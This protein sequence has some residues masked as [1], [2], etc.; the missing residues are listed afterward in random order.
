M[1]RCRWE[2]FLALLHLAAT[3]MCLHEFIAP[4]HGSGTGSPEVSVLM[5][6]KMSLQDPEKLLDK[7]AA[8]DQTPCQWTGVTCDQTTQV[9]TGVDLSN[10]NL[11]GPV[12]TQVC[13]LQNLTSYNVGNNYLG[14]D[15][16]D[17]LLDCSKLEYLNLSQNLIVSLLPNNISKLQNL[18]HLDLCANNFTGAIPPGFGDLPLLESLNLTSNLLNETIPGYLG[19]LYNLK[20]L[21]LAINPFAPGEIPPELGNLNRLVNLHLAMANLVGPIP[22]SFGNLT[23]LTDFLDLS[24]NNL[25]GSIP[26]GIMGLPKLKK[27]ELYI[28]NLT[29]QIP[30]NMTKLVSITD[31]DL[32]ENGLTGTIP[33]DIAKLPNLQLLHLWG[34]Q[35]KGE[36][37]PGL[38]NL[39]NLSMLRLFSNNLTGEL[40]QNFGQQGTAFMYFDVSGNALSGPVPPDLCKGGQLQDLLLFNNKFSG[41]I[42]ET[43]GNC[44]SLQRF[45]VNQNNLNGQIPEALWKAPYLHYADFSDNSFTGGI[46]PSIG[47]AANLTILDVSN[48]RLSGE[49]PPEIGKLFKLNKFLAE[50][51]QFSGSIPPH[52]GNLSSLNV[53]SISDNQLS[54]E[55]PLE[56]SKCHQLSQLNLSR[57]SLTGSIPSALSVLSVLNYLDLSDNKLS[58]EIPI[59]LGKLLFLSFNVSYNDLSGPVPAALSN[60]AFTT[61]F[62]GN[63]HLCGIGLQALAPCSGGAGSSNNRSP[64]VIAVIFAAAAVLLL[65]GS[66]LFFKRYRLYFNH[67]DK[68][69]KAPWSLTSFHKLGF[70]EYEVLGCLDEDHVIGTGGAG[71][72]YKATLSN[73]KEVAV[74]KLWTSSKTE[75]KH[76]YGFSVEVETLGRLRHKNIVKLLCCCSS[77]DAKLLVYEYMPNG[78]LGDQLHGPQASVLDWPTRYHIALGAAEGLAYLHHDYNPPILHCDVKSN[79]ILLDANYEA[80]VADF[81]LAKILQACG[82]AVSM[83]NIAGTYGYIAPEYAYSLKVNEK[84]DIYSFGVVLL[85]LVTGKKPMQ[86]QFVDGV[87]IV[88]WVRTNI[89]RKSEA[90]QLLDTRLGNVFLEEMLTVLRVGLLCTNELPLER[91]SMREVVQMLQE[92]NPKQIG[93]KLSLNHSKSTKDPDYSTYINI[94]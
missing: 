9:V 51:N 77:E 10:M 5:E 74:K 71:K 11:V 34:N 57:N 59:V 1:S 65:V 24:Q 72:V 44:S 36:I 66:V 31:L 35:L 79:N 86:P 25:E 20:W 69:R 47:M 75:A 53:L 85:E 29:G 76:D 39:P 50:Q 38:G 46:S 33:N 6:V 7:W 92:A 4:C 2:V 94:K 30:P 62:L 80:R 73:G 89:Q 84:S 56:I 81:G 63:P 27:M 3:L 64:W 16:P 91:P 14:G 40:P 19:K 88:K 61:S 8:N 54:G 60:G 48:N 43:Y 28:N 15:F 21:D 49:L 82:K 52:V 78:S 26:A 13:Q 37:P 22:D 67:R 83:S 18:K 87:D 58:G 68:N 32:S 41:V 70:S 42:P 45:R 23:E 55:I 12:P 17:K 90:Q 93:S